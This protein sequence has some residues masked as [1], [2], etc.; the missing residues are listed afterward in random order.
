MKFLNPVQKFN[1]NEP[2]LT[3]E[4]KKCDV[5]NDC[6]QKE[7]IIS[8]FVARIGSSWVKYLPDNQFAESA[9]VL[10]VNRMY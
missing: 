7:L 1:Q 8:T 5:T 9:F 6:A 4:L 10:I 3:N 2:N